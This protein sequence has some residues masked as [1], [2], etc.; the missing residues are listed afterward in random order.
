[1][2]KTQL[3]YEMKTQL[4]SLIAEHKS[5]LLASHKDQYNMLTTHLQSQMA[6][7]K[8]ESH[9][10]M[11]EIQRS[12]G[13]EVSELSRQ[14]FRENM[15]TA[16]DTLGRKLEGKLNFQI[17]KFEKSYVKDCDED[18]GFLLE[19]IDILEGDF[20]IR[21]KEFKEKVKVFIRERLGKTE[22]KLTHEIFARIYKEE[23]ET[24]GEAEAKV[25]QSMKKR[26]LI[27]EG[28]TKGPAQ[29]KAAISKV[30]GNRWG[31]S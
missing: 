10:L 26:A 15:Q 14:V 3:E 17:E 4:E 18:H 25:L 6:S 29:K 27:H 9:A 30:N 23:E 21:L 5:S 22:R 20:I 8:K 28:N 31:V 12:G 13:K 11:K 1:M 7:H 16:V 2:L 24:K 19:K